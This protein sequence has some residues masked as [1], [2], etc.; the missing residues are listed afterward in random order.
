MVA[1]S[2]VAG[3]VTEMTQYVL[4]THAN[5]RGTVFGGQIMAWIDLC[6]LITA[7]RHTGASCVTAGVDDLAFVGPVKVGQVV[8]LRAR[9]TAAFRTSLE[10]FVEVEGEDSIGGARWP[11]VSAWLTFVPVGDDGKPLPVPP[12]VPEDD[13]GRRLAA[14]AVERRS[15]RLERARRS[16]SK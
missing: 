5:A 8:R 13:E 3:S 15:T 10:I 11:C 14:E 9:V 4:P 16:R 6:A 2:T 7:Q 12:V 1:P